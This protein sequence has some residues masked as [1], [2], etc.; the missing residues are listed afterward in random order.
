MNKEIQSQLQSTLDKYQGQSVKDVLQQLKTDIEQTL[1]NFIR[2]KEIYV[3]DFPIE[4]E[5]DMGK[6]KINADGSTYVQPKVAAQNITIN[7]T[8]SKTNN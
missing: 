4:F 8:V 2:E 3:G 5:N 1:Q 7:I 6:W